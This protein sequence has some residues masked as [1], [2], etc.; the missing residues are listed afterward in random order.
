MLLKWNGKKEFTLPFRKEEL[1]LTERYFSDLEF[2]KYKGLLKERA[3]PGGV[4]RAV[5]FSNSYA[6]ATQEETPALMPG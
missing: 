4:R 6:T 3:M 2:I 1:T 5:A